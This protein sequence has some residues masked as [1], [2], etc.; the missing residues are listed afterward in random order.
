MQQ[1]AGKNFLSNLFLRTCMNHVYVLVFSLEMRK[2]GQ[3]R[4]CTYLDHVRISCDRLLFSFL[5]L[6]G[7]I[8]LIFTKKEKQRMERERYIAGS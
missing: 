7:I 2:E 3:P 8:F 5:F 1:Q 4:H 6:T